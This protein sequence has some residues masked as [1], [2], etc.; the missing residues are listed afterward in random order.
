MNFFTNPY[1]FLPVQLN[2]STNCQQRSSPTGLKDKII[3]YKR[4]LYLSFLILQH[5]SQHVSLSF[6]PLFSFNF[7]FSF[8]TKNNVFFSLLFYHKVTSQVLIS[9]FF[10]SF[11]QHALPAR[12]VADPLLRPLRRV[13]QH[14]DPRGPDLRGPAAYQQKRQATGQHPDHPG[15]CPTSPSSRYSPS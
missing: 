5:K 10:F 8:H 6:S 9:S 11:S 1:F 13:L 7:I 3:R 15:L 14:R 12:G 4:I 2:H